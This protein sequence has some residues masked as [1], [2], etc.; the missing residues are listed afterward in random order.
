L[1]L[2]TPLKAKTLQVDIYDNSYFADFSLAKD[3]AAKLVSA[4]AQCKLATTGPNMAA[5]PS[6]AP[7]EAFFNS[8]D[9][10]SNWGARF[11]SK[12]VVTCP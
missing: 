5:A 11:A 2:K 4:P 7:N 6:Q 8:L 1:P 12:I 9:Q 3:E 10:S